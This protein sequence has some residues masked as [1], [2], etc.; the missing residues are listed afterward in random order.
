MRGAA[1]P[2]LAEALNKAFDDRHSG[3]GHGAATPV[4]AA[5]ARRRYDIVILEEPA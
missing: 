1:A 4:Q 3:E 5:R 2:G